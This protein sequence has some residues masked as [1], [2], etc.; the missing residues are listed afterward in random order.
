MYKL[1]TNI[2]ADGMSYRG[3]PFGGTSGPFPCAASIPL[4]GLSILTPAP[5]RDDEVLQ[6][7]EDYANDVKQHIRFSTIVKRI[8][9]SDGRWQ[10]QSQSTDGAPAQGETFDAICD[11]SGHYTVPYIPRIEGLWRFKSKLLHSKWYRSPSPYTQQVK[12]QC[13]IKAATTNSLRRTY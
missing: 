4:A 11:A 9:K 8:Y 13:R 3:F 6:Y 2:P 1:R 5:R 12:P 7:I 10:V